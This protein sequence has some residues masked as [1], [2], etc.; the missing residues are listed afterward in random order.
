VR[1]PNIYGI[2]MPS[3]AEL[4]AHGRTEAEIETLLGA[5]WLV[6]QDLADLEASIAEGNDNLHAFDTSC[7]SGEYVTGVE[8]TY[9]DELEFSRSDEAKDRRRQAS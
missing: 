1:Y 4:V 8:P 5:D 6:Y 9:L 3:A 7:F 2:D